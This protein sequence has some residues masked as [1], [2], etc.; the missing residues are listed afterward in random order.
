MVSAD[1]IKEYLYEWFLENDRLTVPGLGQFEASYVGATIQPG[2]HKLTPPNKI[3]T[4]NPTQQADDGVLASYIAQETGISPQEAQ[5]AIRDFVENIKANLQ[6][7]K[8]I[9]L[10]GFGMLVLQPDG[11]IGFRSEEDTNYLGDSFGLGTIFTKPTSKYEAEESVVGL[12]N[13]DLDEPMGSQMG[14]VNIDNLLA[15]DEEI[16]EEEEVVDNSAKRAITILLVAI[17]A[18]SSLFVYF[19]MT[20]TNPFELFSS[21][22]VADKK[23]ETQEPEIEK[24]EKVENNSK[25]EKPQEDTKTETQ[26]PNNQTIKEKPEII[27]PKINFPTDDSF[28]KGFA[29]NPQA[30]AN[31]GK[32][33]VSARASR[34]FVVVGSFGKVDNAYS[35][36]NNL[37]NRGVN[38]AK[39]I[40]PGADNKLY[41]VS[42]GDHASEQAAMNQGNSFGTRNRLSY[43]IYVY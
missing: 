29:Y 6:T 18:I 33:I 25:A 11:S 24:E 1:N 12:D 14:Q 23:T 8:K 19:L 17:L 42:L 20:D 40:P 35:F 34:Y 38:T 30:P 26:K 21:V 22:E 39:I 36:Y 4:F 10:K 41:R 43:W 16:L 7:S 31:S 3:I 27:S 13:D 2:M 32:V 5:Q 37:I 28:V 9:K 15:K